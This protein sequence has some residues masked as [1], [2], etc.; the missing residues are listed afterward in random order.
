MNRQTYGILKKL[1]CFDLE[2][3]QVVELREALGVFSAW[4][5]LQSGLELHA[6]AP[7]AYRHFHKHDLACPSSFMLGLKALALR[8]RAASRIRYQ[9]LSEL[10]QELERRDISILGIKGVAL[11]PLL[12]PDPSLRPMRDMDILVP[13]KRAREVVAVMRLQGFSLPDKQP[14]RYEV[15]NHHLPNATRMVDGMTISIEVHKDAVNNDSFTRITWE[16]GI[17]D[18]QEVGW[19]DITFRTLGHELMLLQ[20]CR[21]LAG[22]QSTL[23]LI[24]VLDVV[25][26][27][28]KFVDDIDW[29]GLGRTQPFV[30]NTLRCLHLLCPLSETVQVWVKPDDHRQLEGVGE[31]MIPVSVALSKNIGFKRKIDKLFNPSE[32]WLYLHYGVRPG[33]SLWPTKL[34]THPFYLG[35]WLTKRMAS[36]LLW[37][38]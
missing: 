14:S 35:Y 28:E 12:Y 30:I 22:T 20:L 1:A 17:T 36:R 18:S 5:T 24:N 33:R 31:N 2:P 38:E 7:L 21:H 19:Q 23:K 25:A 6:I 8:H 11:A 16:K 27:T 29:P 26:Y 10:L 13:G 4:N 9:V 37:S 32:W 15:L 3:D 34:F